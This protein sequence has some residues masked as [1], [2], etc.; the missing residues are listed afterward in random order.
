MQHHAALTQSFDAD[1]FIQIFD[2]L[3]GQKCAKAAKALQKEAPAFASLAE[4][5]LSGSGSDELLQLVAN[6]SKKRS[7]AGRQVE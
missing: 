2:F 3:V 5:P 1:T 7:V 6:G 4:R